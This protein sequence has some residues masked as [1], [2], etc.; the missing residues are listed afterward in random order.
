MSCGS[1]LFP[2]KALRLS[3]DVSLIMPEREPQRFVSE[4][5]VYTED[6]TVKKDSIEVNRPVKIAGW[7]IYQLSYDETKGR[8]SDISIFE[9]VKDPWL[10]A[11]YIGIIMMMLGAVCLFMTAQKGKDKRQTQHLSEDVL[12]SSEEAATSSEDIKRKEALK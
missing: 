3:E 12:A 10:P 1:F 6:G 11:V 4:V 2:Y 5:I 8:W 7:N 9:L